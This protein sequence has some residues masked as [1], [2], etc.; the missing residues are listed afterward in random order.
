MFSRLTEDCELL[1][2]AHGGMVVALQVVQ[3]VILSSGKELH[4]E[5]VGKVKLWGRDT[6]RYLISVT[7][8]FEHD[9]KY[10]DAFSY[11]LVN[12]GYLLAMGIEKD[13]WIWKLKE[14][15]EEQN[16]PE[17]HIQFRLKGH[18]SRVLCCDM[19]EQGHIMTGSQDVQV[20]LWKLGSD[21]RDRSQ[22]VA[23]H[24][25]HGSP[26]ITVRLLW[27]L[28][29]S[30]SRWSVS[31]YYHPTGACLRTIKFSKDVY[32]LHMDHMYFATS[33]EVQYFISVM[34]EYHNI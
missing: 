3:D 16:V 19:D 5:E 12:H 28:G 1:W 21:L 11:L 2:V 4:M 18:Y 33:H 13:V 34:W 31:L 8:P 30:A 9:L 17:I 10:E 15:K 20:R 7:P 25:Q 14:Q 32:D 24:N 27:P 22:A 26:V 29:M 23:C 6:G